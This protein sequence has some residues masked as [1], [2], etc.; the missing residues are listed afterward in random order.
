M[1]R[2][3]LEA[4]SGMTAVA[5]LAPVGGVGVAPPAK[6]MPDAAAA[7]LAFRMLYSA[8]TAVLA[9]RSGRPGSSS[10]G[11]RGPGLPESDL[12]HDHQ[13]LL[14]TFHRAVYP[15]QNHYILIT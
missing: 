12:E 10:A 15:P 2:H 4:K 8:V 14:Q 9:P 3:L 11:E 5:A 6:R 13:P 7:W 1:H